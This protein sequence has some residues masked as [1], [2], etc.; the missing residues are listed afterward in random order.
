MFLTTQTTSG[1]S[2]DTTKSPN[3]LSAASPDTPPLAFELNELYKVYH[4]GKGAVVTAVDRLSLAA[5]AGQVIGLLGP[6][7]AGKTTTIKM[8]C[9]LVTP[10]AGACISTGTTS[11]ASDPW[12]YSRSGQCWKGHAAS[13]GN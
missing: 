2:R 7:G 5:P 12:R 11:P 8:M 13:T 3:N 4:Q 9:G 10:P 6:N 1:D